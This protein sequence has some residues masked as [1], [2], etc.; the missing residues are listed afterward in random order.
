MGKK[1]PYAVSNWENNWGDVSSFFQFFDDIMYT[2]NIIKTL[3]R[4]YPGVPKQKV[5][6]LMTHN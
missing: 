3:N 5:Y 2:T 1:Y 6:S 4:Q